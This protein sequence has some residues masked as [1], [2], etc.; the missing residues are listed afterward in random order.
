MLP[1][2]GK[3]RERFVQVAVLLHLFD[4]VRGEPTIHGLDQDQHE[5]EAPRERLLKR[6]FLDSFALLCATEKDGDSV[7]ATCM[8]EGAPQGTIIRVASNAGVRESTL[9]QLRQVLNLLNGFSD[10]AI[11]TSTAE[12]E[13][14]LH[15]VQIDTVKIQHYLNNIR[16]AKGLFEDSGSA[17]EQRVRTSWGPKSHFDLPSLQRF[18]EWVGNVSMIKDLPA[19]A[20]P[21]NLLP[22]VIWAQEGKRYYL[23]YLKGAFADQSQQLPLWVRAVFKLGRYS[24]ASKVFIQLAS[25]FPALFSPMTVEAVKAPKSTQYTLENQEF[26]LTCVLRRVAG[27]N[28]DAHLTRLAGIWNAADP[29]N[30]FRTAC[31][32]SLTV[33]AEMQLVAFYDHNP[34]AKPS[35]RFLGVSNSRR[36][37]P[38]DSTPGVSLSGL[39]NPD[40]ANTSIGRLDPWIAHSKNRM[41]Y[42]AISNADEDEEFQP[43]QANTSIQ[44]LEDTEASGQRRF[45]SNELLLITRMAILFKRADDSS[46]QDI[47]RMR[48]I[49][50]LPTAD[51]SWSKLVKILEVDD[52]NGVGFAEGRDFLVINKQI[53]ARSAAPADPAPPTTRSAKKAKLT[54]EDV[55]LED[56]EIEEAFNEVPVDDQAGAP[57]LHLYRQQPLNQ[58]RSL[59]PQPFS[60]L[61]GPA[62]DLEDSKQADLKK[63]KNLPRHTNLTSWPNTRSPATSYKTEWSEYKDE[64]DEVEAYPSAAVVLAERTAVAAKEAV[65]TVN[66]T[67][68]ARFTRFE[69]DL[70]TRLEIPPAA[71]HDDFVRMLVKDVTDAAAGNK[72]NGGDGGSA[73]GGA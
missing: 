19:D 38:A 41:I 14:L 60:L 9:I 62:Q 57:G 47:V 65:L 69:A 30:H 2:T 28:A 25:E 7:S 37:I 71:G 42:E 20:D 13:I 4:P 32:R 49:L 54:T 34:H 27:A 44:T 50:D 16:K 66:S 51:L 40:S 43:E 45:D 72:D 8:E 58:L 11:D 29:E 15:I 12:T 52:G 18:L 70:R 64:V 67:L 63:R 68:L 39:T 23:E 24:I 10:S 26:P 1:I 31:S 6:K 36:P 3:I 53:H 33:H 21:T 22:I 55:E 48:D 35:I 56:E 5:V 17:I 73:K 59:H 46:R 61:Q